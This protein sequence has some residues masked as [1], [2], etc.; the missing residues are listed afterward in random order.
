MGS[1]GLCILQRGAHTCVGNVMV[2][3]PTE[4]ILL[5][6]LYC[7]NPFPCRFP[8]Q[9][10]ELPCFIQ[11]VSRRHCHC[12]SPIYCTNNYKIQNMEQILK[13]LK[14]LKGKGLY[15]I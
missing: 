6:S 2:T 3:L 7:N 9:T 1:V 14:C 11:L 8:L 4:F 10:N 12:S 13:P 15:H 5:V